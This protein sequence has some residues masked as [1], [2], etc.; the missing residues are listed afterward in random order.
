MA[1]PEPGEGGRHSIRRILVALDASAD[2][3]AAL[4]AAAAL[5]ALLGAELQGLYVEDVNLVR[6]PRLS[7]VT[8]IDLLSGE[9][10]RLDPAELEGHLRRQAARARRSLERAAGHARVRWTFRIARGRVAA[11]LL[12]AEADL[13]TLG[14]RGHSPRRGP[15]STARE[16]LEGAREPVLLLRRGARLGRTVYAVHDGSPAAREAVRVAADLARRQGAPLTVLTRNEGGIRRELEEMLVGGEGEAGARPLIHLAPLPD[17]PAGLA[18][19][20]RRHGCGLLVLPRAG[21]AVA[22]DTLPHLVRRAH[23][24]VLVV[25]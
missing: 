22:L 3:T 9:P 12:A 6:L 8:E 4:E 25:G 21:E 1:A 15:G 24:P 18:E 16:L 2:S 7:L 11:E 14:I 20:V 13:V 5:A 19:T 17:D 10:R 23:C